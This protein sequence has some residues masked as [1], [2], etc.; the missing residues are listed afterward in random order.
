MGSASHPACPAP[1][2]LHQAWGGTAGR[3]C[4]FHAGARKAFLQKDLECLVLAGPESCELTCRKVHMCTQDLFLSQGL[5]AWIPRVIPGS[6]V[7][8]CAGHSHEEAVCP[9]VW[10]TNASPIHPWSPSSL[11]FLTGDLHNHPLI[12]AQVSPKLSRPCHGA[13]QAPPGPM[14]QLTPCSPL[15]SP[16]KHHF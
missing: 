6:G 12:S 3:S 7:M 10:G 8:L 11:P 1:G 14:G 9:C 4:W 15:L 16:P 5:C 2:S 13:L